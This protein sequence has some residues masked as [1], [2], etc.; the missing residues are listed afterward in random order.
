MNMQPES[1]SVVVG[2]TLGVKLTQ[3]VI[4]MG[5]EGTTVLP[6]YA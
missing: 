5:V 1:P 6:Q 3:T 2:E 4:K